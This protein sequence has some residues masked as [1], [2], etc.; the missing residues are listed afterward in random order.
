MK[1]EPKTEPKNEDEQTCCGGSC[2]DKDKSA[3]SCEQKCV[4]LTVEELT[5]M[6]K[7]TQANFDN[8]RKQMQA[9]NE[10]VRKMASRDIVL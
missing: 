6:L 1:T 3:E 10:E 8:Y 2:H 4:S 9:Y 5:D 7:R